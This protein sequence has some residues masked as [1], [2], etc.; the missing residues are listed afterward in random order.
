M[1]PT[2]FVVVLW[3][4][5]KKKKHWLLKLSLIAIEMGSRRDMI[6]RTNKY[7]PDGENAFR[8]RTQRDGKWA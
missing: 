7:N 2:L 1:G 4:V 6:S 5:K 8:S 3:T